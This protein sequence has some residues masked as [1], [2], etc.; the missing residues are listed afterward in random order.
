MDA[1]D[2]DFCQIQLNY[3]DAEVQAGVKGLEY[4]G[5]KGLP[6]VIMEPLKGGKLTDNIPRK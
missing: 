6:V 1:H 3:M 4:A 5:E 2:W